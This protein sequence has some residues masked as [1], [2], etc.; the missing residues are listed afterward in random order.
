MYTYLENLATYK[1][2]IMKITIM[3]QIGFT[4]EKGHVIY[5]GHVTLVGFI[6]YV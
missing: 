4:L 2:V 6:I 5:A 1:L 3:R